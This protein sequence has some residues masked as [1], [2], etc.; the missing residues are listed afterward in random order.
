M[1]ES[2]RT[3][4]IFA[5]F[6]AEGALARHD[7]PARASRPFDKARNGIVVSEGGC[8]YALER[9]DD[10]LTRGARIFGEVVG[11]CVNSDAVDFVLP[12]AERQNECMRAA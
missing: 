4:G 3:F 9:L 6:A 12:L 11:H 10:A 5:S 8:L 7:D 1:S 2:I